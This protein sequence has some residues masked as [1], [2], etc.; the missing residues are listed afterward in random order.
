MG[1]NDDV[2][3]PKSVKIAGVRYTIIRESMA[4][5]GNIMFGRGVIKINDEQ[6]QSK[7]EET[8]CHEIMEAINEANELKLPHHK[9]QT[10]GSMLHQILK[11]NDL[12]MYGGK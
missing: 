8:L 3:L 11:D 6:C 1:Y 5:G 2:K 4:D 7:S 9:I 10:I 12:N